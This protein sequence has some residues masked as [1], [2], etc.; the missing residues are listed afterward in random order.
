ML[1]KTSVVVV[2]RL[3][4][5]TILLKKLIAASPP[6][7]PPTA[8]KAL[9]F[10]ALRYPKLRYPKR[11]KPIRTLMLAVAPST[12]AVPNIVGLTA[13]AAVSAIT[14][15]GLV[16]G[17]QT[18]AASPTVAYGLIISQSPSAGSSVALGT[19]V[20]YVLSLGP[21]PVWSSAVSPGTI[22]K[23]VIIAPIVLVPGY[24]SS[25]SGDTL[26][27]S[28][29]S[30][31][32][33]DG[34]TLSSDGI[35]TGFPFYAGNY[36]FTVLALDVVTGASAVSPAST[37]SVAFENDAYNAPSVV[38]LLLPDA[39]QIISAAGIEVVEILYVD[40]NYLG[41]QT[42]PNVVLSQNPSAGTL[43]DAMALGVATGSVFYPSSTKRYRITRMGSLN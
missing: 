23:G 10:P 43:T 34:L 28:V 14:G 3:K 11:R 8:Y 13:G 18:T 41:T 33:P 39:L 2:P 29:A 7:N 20:A 12:A 6:T 32:L 37:I 5:R 30:G 15:V 35:I 21:A 17:A 16:V 38:G 40:T 19:S 36:H 1:V 42:K 25:P 4:R 22:A 27:F 9:T 31:A 26:T 24:V